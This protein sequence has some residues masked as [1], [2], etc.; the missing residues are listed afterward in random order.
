[1]ALGA[2]LKLAFIFRSKLLCVRPDPP[3]APSLAVFGVES[4]A[5]GQS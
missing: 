1:M 2:P 3:S 4:N 5:L